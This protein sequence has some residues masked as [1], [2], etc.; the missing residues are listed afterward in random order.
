MHVLNTNDFKR[1]RAKSIDCYSRCLH[2][3]V[4]GCMPWLLLHINSVLVKLLERA[5]RTI[6]SIDS[7]DSI[8]R[9]DT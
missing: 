4:D 8:D 6:D 5:A 7:I 3:R 9:I 2:C 1:F